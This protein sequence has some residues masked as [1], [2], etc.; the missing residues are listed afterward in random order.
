[1]TEFD[2]D[3]DSCLDDLA[4]QGIGEAALWSAGGTGT[5]IAATVMVDEMSDSLLRERLGLNNQRLADI[6]VP[7]ALI[8][9]PQREDAITIS[10]ANSP[11]Y[12]TWIAL[13]IER[14]TRTH[15][16]IRCRL[17]TVQRPGDSSA[18]EVRR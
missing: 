8:A 3:L 10:D 7:V 1:M 18:R 2:D 12:G 15:R 17:A 6:T 16:V 4:G 11:Y 5:P 13:G 14:R 9:D